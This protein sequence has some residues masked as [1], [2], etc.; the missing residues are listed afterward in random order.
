MVSSATAASG[1]SNVL[2]TKAG[3]FTAYVYVKAGDTRKQVH[4]PITLTAAEGALALARHNEPVPTAPVPTAPTAPTVPS[5]SPA[6]SP[7]PTPAPA[8][9]APPNCPAKRRRRSPP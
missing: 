3:R 9:G 4:F 1:Y 8:P 5:P 2:V 7:S 6:P